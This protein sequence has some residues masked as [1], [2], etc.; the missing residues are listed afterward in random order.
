MNTIT[1]Y[2][3]SQPI[4]IILNGQQTG[5]CFQDGP[6]RQNVNTLR[7]SRCKETNTLIPKLMCMWLQE[8]IYSNK[9]YLLVELP[10]IFD[11][12]DT[13]DGDTMSDS[14]AATNQV[15]IINTMWVRCFKYSIF[16]FFR[17]L[18]RFHVG[19][20]CLMRR[21]PLS[22]SCASSPDNNSL[23]D[24]S[25]LMLSNHLLFGLVLFLFPGTSVTITLLPT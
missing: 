19:S 13:P 2:L 8:V 18:S 1:K 24:K 16:F 12:H 17:I 10:N 9:I 25:F 6:P 5:Y 21:L 4:S 3:T 20:M 11:P 14:F 15:G 7:L 22:R 23:S